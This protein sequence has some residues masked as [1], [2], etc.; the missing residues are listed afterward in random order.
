MLKTLVV[1]VAVVI[2]SA[3]SKA[4]GFNNDVAYD[5]LDLDYLFE[6]NGLKVFKFAFLSKLDSSLN[7]KVEEYKNGKRSRTIDWYQDFKPMLAMGDDPLTNLFPK[8]NDSIKLT[9]R[10][11]L[12]QKKDTLFVDIKN[13]NISS[14]Y[15]FLMKGVKMS[16]ARAY[17]DIPV[18]L[19]GKQPLFILYGKKEGNF[20]SCPGNETAENAAKDYPYVLAFYADFLVP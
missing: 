15:T 16:N 4:Q 11:Y 7:I 19:S 20:I 13:N 12:E 1:L 2:A 17:D 6:K 9:T 8:L 10:F 18:Y 3:Q 5:K 14:N